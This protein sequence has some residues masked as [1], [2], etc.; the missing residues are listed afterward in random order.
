MEPDI[1]NPACHHPY[2]IISPALQHST[3]P[4]LSASFLFLFHFFAAQ[5]HGLEATFHERHRDEPLGMQHAQQQAAGR[6]SKFT[7]S[8]IT[9]LCELRQVTSSL[10]FLQ[11]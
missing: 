5:S 2:Y 8:L 4:L 7:A 11:V 1:A 10:C 3:I 6:W 9:E